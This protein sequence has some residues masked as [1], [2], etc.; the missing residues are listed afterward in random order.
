MKNERKPYV[1]SVP[2]E[3]DDE[4]LAW[5]EMRRNGVPM[6]IIAKKTGHTESNLNTLVN[7]I[8]EAD[9]SY[10][11]EPVHRV[12]PAYGKKL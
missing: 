5:L 12:L 11:R 3:R 9:L 2:R 10:S 7:R 4:H 6:R 1:M 8:M